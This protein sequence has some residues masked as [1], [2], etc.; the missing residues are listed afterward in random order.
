MSFLSNW[1]RQNKKKNADLN[2]IKDN[3]NKTEGVEEK[4]QTQKT[5]DNG[6]LSSIKG[7]SD[8]E[9]SITRIL[10]SDKSVQK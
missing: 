4:N 5:S 1:L 10:H 2:F 7:N 3:E 9:N 8:N 6:R